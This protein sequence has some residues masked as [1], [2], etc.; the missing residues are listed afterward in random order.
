VLLTDGESNTG[1][2]S[3]AF[4]ARLAALAADSGLP[5]RTF[6]ILFGEGSPGEI[7][8]IARLTGGRSFDGLRGDLTGVL[9][10]IRGYQ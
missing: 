5:A 2:S 3:E 4:Q 1:L 6:P 9:K 8:G 7:E 10:E